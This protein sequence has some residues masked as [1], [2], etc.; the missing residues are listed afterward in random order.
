[1]VASP[2]TAVSRIMNT[3]WKRQRHELRKEHFDEARAATRYEPLRGP[4]AGSD[5]AFADYWE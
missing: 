5:N 1:M 3:P 4:S 2:S